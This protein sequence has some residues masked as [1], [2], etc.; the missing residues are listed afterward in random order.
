MGPKLT[1]AER[2]FLGEGRCDL[3]NWPLDDPVGM[4]G[5]KFTKYS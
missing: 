2:F 1:Q 3:R 4:R 5:E